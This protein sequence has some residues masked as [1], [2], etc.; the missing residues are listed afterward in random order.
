MNNNDKKLGK[1]KGGEMR[2]T[3][4]LNLSCNIISLRFSHCVINLSLVAKV[5]RGIPSTRNRNLKAGVFKSLYFE[6][7]S[8]KAL[9]S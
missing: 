2:D 5:E 3:K 8:G 6:E 1:P 9:L 4:T 7:R